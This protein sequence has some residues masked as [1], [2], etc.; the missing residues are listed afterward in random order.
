MREAEH[1]D[2]ELVAGGKRR[3]YC[4]F[5]LG[6]R[7]GRRMQTGGGPSLNS[8]TTTSLTS[9]GSGVADRLPVRV[10]VMSNQPPGPSLMLSLHHW[11]NCKE[12]SP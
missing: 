1:S 10:T 6:R 9:S 12:Q 2:D 8:S 11:L 4:Y 7:G 5:T 3:A